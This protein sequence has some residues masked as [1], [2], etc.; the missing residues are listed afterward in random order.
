MPRKRVNADDGDDGDDAKQRLEAFLEKIRTMVRDGNTTTEQLE[1]L[2][3]KITCDECEKVFSD[4]AYVMFM[5]P[6]YIQRDR[7]QTIIYIYY[8]FCRAKGRHKR[9]HHGDR[10][11]KISQ[12]R[13]AKDSDR[14]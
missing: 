10:V 4:P 7:K 5:I 2:F 6:S 3:A 11:R 12:E 1:K 9:E 14:I 13:K 8:A